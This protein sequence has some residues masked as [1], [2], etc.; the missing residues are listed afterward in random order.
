MT[1]K[2]IKLIVFTIK[3]LNF[4]LPI[5]R[6]YKILNRTTIYSSGTNQ[7]GIAHISDREITVIDLHRRFF[8]ASLINESESNGY[9]VILQNTTGELY[10]IPVAEAPILMDVPLSTIRV[11]PETYRQADTLEIA[12]HVAV[13]PQG[14]GALTVFLLDVDL[15]LPKLQTT[16]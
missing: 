2:L 15:L 4:S 13:I 12:R 8:K 14:E 11:L 16:H 7:V 5:E 1:K 6:V 10:G 9:L 3:N